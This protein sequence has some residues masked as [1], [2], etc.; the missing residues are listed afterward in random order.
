MAHLDHKEG[1]LT[2]SQRQDRLSSRSDSEDEY[3]LATWELR[4]GGAGVFYT[5]V[6]ALIEAW[7]QEACEWVSMESQA[8]VTRCKAGQG[9]RS[10]TTRGHSCQV[11]KVWL[12]PILAT[13]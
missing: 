11:K 1:D 3:K 2:Q 13:G 6:A 10:H 12:C 8:G 5:K 4:V 9:K 7:K